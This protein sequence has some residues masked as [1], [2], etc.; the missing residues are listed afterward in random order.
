MRCS[1]EPIATLA[2][3]ATKN[4]QKAVATSPHDG[5]DAEGSQPGVGRCA[6]GA[7]GV[8]AAKTT[9]GQVS[10]MRASSKCI[11]SGRSQ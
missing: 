7:R 9:H 3:L 5:Q 1:C 8:H 11:G 10:T 6:L 2:S 4:M